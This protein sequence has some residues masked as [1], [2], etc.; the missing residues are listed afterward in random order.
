M[1]NVSAT[2]ATSN[3]AITISE[4][5]GVRILSQE[6]GKLKNQV[7]RNPMFKIYTNTPLIAEKNSLA[8]L[9]KVDTATLQF[10]KVTLNNLKGKPVNGRYLNFTSNALRLSDKSACPRTILDKWI[11]DN[12][13]YFNVTE[14]AIRVVYITLH[15]IG[16]ELRSIGLLD[17]FSGK[18]VVINLTDE[19][20]NHPDATCIQVQNASDLAI[21]LMDHL[22][23][24]SEEHLVLALGFRISMDGAE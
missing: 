23:K 9:P 17:S 5:Q 3:L 7:E 11:L 10:D 14:E 8:P 1:K 15:H 20:V 12:E 13:C 2:N 18:R 4:K 6:N 22:L 19:N 24:L 21:T 16:R